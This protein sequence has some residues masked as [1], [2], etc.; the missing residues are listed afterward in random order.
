M[1]VSALQPCE[2]G[3]CLLMVGD[4]P[5]GQSFKSM[6]FVLHNISNHKA[7]PSNAAAYNDYP[8]VYIWN[9]QTPS[10]MNDTQYDALLNVHV[11][12]NG[13]IIIVDDGAFAMLRYASS[14]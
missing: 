14:M 12:E 3:E 13:G 5:N 6:G 9:Y 7:L 10:P 4:T 11:Y 1:V 8:A 2:R